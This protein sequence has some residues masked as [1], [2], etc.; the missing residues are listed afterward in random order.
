MVEQAHDKRQTELP[1]PRQAGAL[2]QMQGRRRRAPDTAA[3]ERSELRRDRR[4]A[5]DVLG[6]R[7]IRQGA[8]PC[9]PDG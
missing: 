5:G 2:P 8:L 6:V 7:R 4:Q 1:W 3:R 9:R